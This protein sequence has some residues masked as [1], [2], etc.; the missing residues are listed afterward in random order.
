MGLDTPEL[1]LVFAHLMMGFIL[2]TGINY[3]KCTGEPS[4]AFVCA[5]PHCM[6]ES[7]FKWIAWMLVWELIIGWKLAAL[8]L[9][10]SHRFF[11]SIGRRLIKPAPI[12]PA[13]VI[14]R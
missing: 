12:P 8:I 14:N 6:S 13:K 2:D 9:R 7:G 5:C 11:R 3:R 10:H 4:H 1:L